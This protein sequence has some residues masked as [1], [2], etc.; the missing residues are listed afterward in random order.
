LLQLQL[1]NNDMRSRLEEA[2]QNESQYA[3]AARETAR[4][5]V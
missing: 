4:K 3:V 2:K 1:T 5:Q